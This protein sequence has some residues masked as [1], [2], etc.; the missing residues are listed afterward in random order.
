MKIY[1]QQK[2]KPIH[3][4]IS[5]CD[6]GYFRNSTNNGCAV[7]AIGTYSDTP[8]ADSCTSCPEGETTS[9]EGSTSSSQCG[10]KHSI[11]FY[12]LFYWLITVYFELDVFSYKLIFW[13]F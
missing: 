4:P 1:E 2:R 10:K 13:L 8:N 9:D 7:C 11:L 12:Q 6:M 5:G 3:F